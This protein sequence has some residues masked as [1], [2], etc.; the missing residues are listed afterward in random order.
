M[1][2]SIPLSSVLLPYFFST[3]SGGGGGRFSFRQAL[4]S[5]SGG[6]KPPIFPD[7]ILVNGSYFMK[8]VPPDPESS[9]GVDNFWGSF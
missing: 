4:D 5:G 9:A 1:V 2:P 3:S 8:S 7:L 6:T